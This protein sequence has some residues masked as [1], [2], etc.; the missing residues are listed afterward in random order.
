MLLE[1]SPYGKRGR[2]AVEL[3]AYVSSLKIICS[4]ELA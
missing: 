2:D 1:E 3:W 4:T